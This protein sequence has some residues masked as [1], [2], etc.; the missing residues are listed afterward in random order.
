[1]SRTKV[2][3]LSVVAICAGAAFGAGQALHTKAIAIGSVGN[4][5]VSSTMTHFG[6]DPTSN[7]CSM[8]SHDY[9]GV[10]ALLRNG[11]TV[12]D[13]DSAGYDATALAPANGSEA[14]A[15]AGQLIAVVRN[16]ETPRTVAASLRALPWVS[17]AEPIDA[18]SAASDLHSC[19]HDL[20]DKPN[21]ASL[22]KD[23]ELAA[24]NAGYLSGQ[25]TVVMANLSD[26]PTSSGDV[27]LTIDSRGPVACTLPGPLGGP[28]YSLRATLAV[29][30]LQGV[31]E[32]IGSAPWY[33]NQTGATC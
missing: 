15:Q 14:V 20:S 18:T 29:V 11:F 6:L 5:G 8:S 30:T 27:L 31:V 3:L 7:Y 13:A 17:A 4:R 21:A 12:R 26:D 32:Q 10:V 28:V 33:D 25:S 2:I 1:M 22:L 9:I 23:A 24:V 16:G 19:M